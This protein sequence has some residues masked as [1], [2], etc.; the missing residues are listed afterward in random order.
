[1]EPEPTAQ[2]VMGQRHRAV[3]KQRNSFPAPMTIAVAFASVLVLGLLSLAVTLP[4]DFWRAN[5]SAEKSDRR[6]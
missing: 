6:Y 4:S 1:M 5:P 2:C 3:T